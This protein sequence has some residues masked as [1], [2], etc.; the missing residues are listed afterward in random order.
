[1]RETLDLPLFKMPSLCHGPSSSG[2]LS[3]SRSAKLDVLFQMVRTD[4]MRY[5]LSN[6]ETT[7]G[8]HPHYQF[9]LKSEQ[10]PPREF[11]LAKLAA[12]A[13]RGVSCSPSGHAHAAQIDPMARVPPSHGSGC[14]HEG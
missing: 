13:S 9:D 1:M 8:D 6:Y 11:D 2:L 12:L 5:S 10:L 3:S 4:L 14:P 7:Y